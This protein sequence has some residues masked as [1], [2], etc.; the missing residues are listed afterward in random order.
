RMRRHR[1]ENTGLGEELLAFHSVEDGSN[2]ERDDSPV[3]TVE[4]FEHPALTALPDDLEG[5]VPVAD[6]VSHVL[7]SAPWAPRSKYGHLRAARRSSSMP[8]GPRSA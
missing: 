7:R 3:L 2:L 5:L 6:E 1:E 4:G 8:S